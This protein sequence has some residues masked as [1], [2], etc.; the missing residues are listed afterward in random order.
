[1][2]GDPPS[3]A[4]G[5]KVTVALLVPTSV[6]VPIVGAPGTLAALTLFDAPEYALCPSALIA[7]TAKVTVVPVY[8]PVTVH[9]DAVQV[10]VMP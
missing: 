10:P 3:D 5:V 9:G 2:I 8:K 6:A 1:V 7:L 4:G